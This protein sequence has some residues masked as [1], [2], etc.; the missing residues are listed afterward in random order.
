ME[1][2][3]IN[4]SIEV[5]AAFRKSGVLPR[6]FVWQGRKYPV[7]Q[8]TYMWR[9]RLGE[10]L[11][12]YFTVTDGATSFEISLNHLTLSWTLEKTILAD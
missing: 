11:L 3:V 6:W 4:E 2:V 9:E 8:I 10:A 12:S 1:S 5:G 7:Q